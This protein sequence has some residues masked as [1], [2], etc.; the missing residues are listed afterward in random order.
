M[1]PS[2]DTKNVKDIKPPKFSKKSGFYEDEFLLTLSTEEQSEIFYT[3]D[4]SNPFNSGTVQKYTEPIKI[5]DRS[6]E[7]NN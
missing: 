6:E 1:L 4:G 2:P 3:I 7:P 5:Y